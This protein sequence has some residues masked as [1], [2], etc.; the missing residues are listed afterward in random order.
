MPFTVVLHAGEC[1]Q[2]CP[3]S[4]PTHQEICKTSRDRSACATSVQWWLTEFPRGMHINWWWLDSSLIVAFC[5]AS[6]TFVVLLVVEIFKVVAEA[7]HCDLELLILLIALDHLILQT[8]LIDPRLMPVS[9][10]VRSGIHTYLESVHMPQMSLQ[11]SSLKLSSWWLKICFPP[12]CWDS[13][14]SSLVC[15]ELKIQRTS[16]HLG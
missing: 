9:K 10:N 13:L 14:E 1:D 12:L 5:W 8:D 7:I 3:T 11:H 4:R 6:C 15:W 2:W 16:K